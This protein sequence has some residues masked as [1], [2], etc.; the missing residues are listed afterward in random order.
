MEVN[1]SLYLAALFWALPAAA[2]MKVYA[3]AVYLH[4]TVVTMNPK[5]PTAEAVA[6]QGGKI[7]AVGGNAE[8]S[9]LA[10]PQT[11][12]VELQGKTMIPGFYAA[13]DHFVEAGTAAL[14]SV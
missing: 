5:S 14:Y 13:H 10:S 8:I 1:R 3:D 11:Q 7:L 12:V 2:Q 9:A 6:V 4:G